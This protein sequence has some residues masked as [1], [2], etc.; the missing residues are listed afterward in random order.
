M[1]THLSNT[2]CYELEDDAHLEEDSDT[3]QEDS[4][5]NQEDSDT[6]QENLEEEYKVT[7]LKSLTNGYVSEE[8]YN[9]RLKW[10]DNFL[11]TEYNT[12]TKLFTAFTR[13]VFNKQ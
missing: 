2:Y 7:L 11:T 1:S 8:N 12:L 4:D 6:N 13:D 5:T 10:F 3:N 9:K